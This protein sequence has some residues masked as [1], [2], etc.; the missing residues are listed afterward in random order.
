MN[1]V[2]NTI[3][4]SKSFNKGIYTLLFN[5]LS[6]IE[7]SL[8]LQGFS[9]EICVANSTNYSFKLRSSIMAL[10]TV[11]SVGLISLKLEPNCKLSFP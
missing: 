7:N 1:L 10:S 3:T 2:S 9:K 8:I 4:K 6:T 11:N 5:Y